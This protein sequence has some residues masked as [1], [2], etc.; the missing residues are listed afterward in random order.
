MRTDIDQ[1]DSGDRGPLRSWPADALAPRPAQAWTAVVFLAVFY[2]VSYIDRLILSLLIQPI[3]ADLQVSDTQIGLLIGTSFA[4][5]YT[6]FGLPLARFADRTNRRNLI[7]AGALLW[8]AM[9]VASAFATSFPMLVVLRIGVALGE[10]VLL[11]SA[12]SMIGD[13][14]VR[15]KRSLPTSV[16]VGVGATGGAGALIV[17]AAGLQFVSQPWVTQLPFV[18]GMDPWRLTLLFIGGPGTLIALLFFLLVREPRRIDQSPPK[19]PVSE[20]FSHMKANVR[21]YVGLFGVAAL[22]ALLNLGVLAWY[23]T[24]LVRSFGLKASDAGYLFGM[25]G[26]ATTLVGGLTVPNIADWLNR[27]GRHDGFIWAAL[28][29]ILILT[30]LLI[31]SLRAP[32]ATVS[33]AFAAPAFLVMI[34]MGIMCT[35]TVPLLPPGHLRGQVA[36]LYLLVANAVGL[37]VGP[38]L[39]ALLSDKLFP[40]A[41]GLGKSI[42][43]LVL[44]IV[45][46][47]IVLL[48]WS[49]KGFAVS[50]KTAAEHEAATVAAAALARGAPGSY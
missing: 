8:N 40:G 39:I 37:G 48:L 45:P 33:L 11:P 42:A 18:G 26:V 12:L 9:T 23:P 50:L 22:I 20:V 10:A 35:A 46:V 49:R 41:E 14:F 24:H 17:G 29:S 5:F 43:A 38:L 13:L 21:A 28:V 25:I 34:G 27:K 4:I 19:A 47:Q 16:F 30:P 1:K 6:L 31:I 44:I 36:A 7:F 32:T 15:E 3:K 2:L